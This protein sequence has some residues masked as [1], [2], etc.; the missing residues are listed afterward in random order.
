MFRQKILSKD[1]TTKI[2]EKAAGKIP[3]KMLED[4]LSCIEKEIKLH[5]FTKSSESNLLRIIQNQFDIAFFINECL[6]YPHQIE[7]LISLSNNSNYLTDILVRNPEYFHWIINPSVL[8]QKNDVKYF[9]SSLEKTTSSFK[10][11]DSKVNAI[12]NFKRKEIL[13]IGLKDIY[14]KE[15]LINITRYLTELANSISS[16]LFDL[17]YKEI[18]AKHGI[19]NPKIKYAVFSLGKLGGNELNYSSD[20]DL[21]AFYDKNSLVNKKIY[22]NQILS[23]TILLFIETAS[24]KTGS[25]FLYRVD[26]RLRPDG[27]NAPLC[28][29]YAEYLRYYE[30]RGEDWERQMLIKANFLCGNKSL[31]KKFLDYVSRFVYPA[32]FAVSPIEQIRKLKSSIEKRNKSDENIKL[33]SGGIRDIE[34]SVQALQLLNGGKDILVRS[35]NTI[36]TIETLK[37]KKILTENEA[38]IFLNAYIF[39]R[40]AE[41]YLQLMND[42]Q[43][44]TI[45]SEGEIAEK[46]AHFLGFKDLK[47]FK[48]TLESSKDK[49]QSVYNSIVGIEKSAEAKIDFNRIKFTDAQR[50]QNNYEFLRTGK[51]L[52]EKKQFD[53]RTI[54][55]FERIEGQL[56]TFLLSSIQPDLVLENFSRIIKTAHFPQIWFEEFSDTIFFILFLELCEKSQKAIDLFAEDKFLRDN[57]LSRESLVPITKELFSNLNLKTFHF[58][59]AIQ[60]TAKLLSPQSFSILYTEFLDYK[61]STLIEEFTNDKKWRGN[62]FIAAMG[63]FGA[64]VL[65]FSSDIDLVFVVSDIHKYPDLQKDFQKILKTLKDN[66]PGLDI[67]CRLRPEGKSSQL[68]WDIND[69][70]KYFSNRARVWELQS[71]T[72]CRLLSGNK[73]L[74][75]N[76]IDH[77]VETVKGKDQKLIKSEMIEMRKKL[78]P[79]SDD[80]FNLKKSP[81]G[82]ADIDFIISFLLLTNPNF[83]TKRTNNSFK[84]SFDVLKKKN[85]KEVSIDLLESNFYFLKRIELVNQY[86]FN[87]KLSKVPTEELKLF[88]LSKECGFPDSK[89]FIDKL[90]LTIKQ[91]RKEYQNIFN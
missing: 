86:V 88:K 67:D 79:I 54:S 75:S 36:N 87:T 82:L 80:S 45:P 29:S 14:L 69:Y 6:K 15:E 60:L 66:F 64:S 25:G 68:V 32:S 65:S 70:K 61:F 77:L 7:I 1:F 58:R 26:F 21:V 91:T 18:L 11:F 35:G 27:R 78:Y 4:F 40:K 20:I 85:C 83:L 19:E 89:S 10:Y 56:I 72:K 41:H 47:T 23:E 53:S 42:R 62:C 73:K 3:P 31:Y 17:C 55:S 63:S 74:F 76:F 90:N 57:F 8:D 49:V 71:F 16:V 13:R 81:G 24:K 33:V 34:F 44:H 37:Q 22:C 38:N 50:A 5:Y 51:N 59:S 48:E 12:R 46:L 39:Y 43:T 2:I 28:A 52:F 9:T 84:Y 30:M